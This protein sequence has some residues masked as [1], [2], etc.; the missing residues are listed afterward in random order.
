[1]RKVLWSFGFLLTLGIVVNLFLFSLVFCKKLDLNKATVEELEALPGIGKKTAQAIIEY[2]EKFGPFKS[3]EELEKVKGIGPKKVQ[4]LKAYVTVYD[5]K[6]SS[7]SSKTIKSKKDV[8]ISS[9]LKP[10]VYYYVDENGVVH[11]T[12]FPEKVPPKYRNSLK[13]LE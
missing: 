12:Q 1:M 11:Y 9:Q 10:C 4:T 8:N 6:S 5:E 3:V 2:R 13:V 7:K